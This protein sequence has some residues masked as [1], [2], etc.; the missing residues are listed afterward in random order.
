MTDAVFD[1]HQKWNRE[2]LSYGLNI[3]DAKLYGRYSIIATG[4]MG[5]RD[6]LGRY[7]VT[8]DDEKSGSD[9]KVKRAPE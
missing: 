2:R 8:I 3:I 1:G 9:M 4:R 7:G 6:R 5:S